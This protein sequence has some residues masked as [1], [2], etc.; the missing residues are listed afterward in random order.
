MVD[1]SAHDGNSAL[2]MLTTAMDETSAKKKSPLSQPTNPVSPTP[3]DTNE[4]RYFHSIDS[5]KYKCWYLVSIPG[6]NSGP[7]EH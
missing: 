1:D 7:F 2:K 6:L 3:K 4:L 5:L